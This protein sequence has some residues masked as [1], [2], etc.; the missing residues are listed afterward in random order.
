MAWGGREGANPATSVLIRRETKLQMLTG[1]TEHPAER[2]LRPE[3][4]AYKLR[5]AKD[6]CNNQKLKDRH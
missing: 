3:L 6:R 4:C 5:D 1:R 2:R